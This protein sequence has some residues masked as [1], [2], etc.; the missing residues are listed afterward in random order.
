MKDIPEKTFPMAAEEGSESMASGED[1][2]G[3]AGGGEKLSIAKNED[4]VVWALRIFT[5][6]LLF[7]VAV[8][9]CVLA[10]KNA[11]GAQE[12]DFKQGFQEYSSKLMSGVEFYVKNRV[13]IVEGFAMDLSY[14]ANGS[15]PFY[16][17][18][19]Y[20]VRAGHVAKLANF[21]G[22]SLA[23][24][25]ETDQKTAWEAYVQEH[26]G[27]LAEELARQRGIP[28]EEVKGIFIPRVILA[29]KDGVPGPDMGEGPY[30]PAWMSYPP[31]AFPPLININSYGNP[32]IGR[33]MIDAA[34]NKTTMPFSFSEDFMDEP[35]TKHPVALL[36][37]EAL[38][39][40]AG[41]PFF[42]WSYP[43]YDSYTTSS[44]EE[45]NVVALVRGGST[46]DGYFAN[47][48]QSGTP[49]LF[50][51]LENKCNQ[52]YTFGIEGERAVVL[53]RG[54]LH[55]PKYDD[56]VLT[57]TLDSMWGEQ[58]EDDNEEEYGKAVPGVTVGD[59]HYRVRVYPTQEFEDSYYT[60]EPL[61]YTLTLAAVFLFTCMVFLAFDFFVERRQKA[62]LKS[63]L[64]SGKLVSTLFPE[65]VRNQLYKEEEAK[66][67]AKQKE[68]GWLAATTPDPGAVLGGASEG[69]TAKQAIANLYPETTIFF[70]DLAGFTKW[71]STRTPVE[72]FELL[73]ALYGQFDSIAARYNVFKV[74]TIGDCYVAVRNRSSRTSTRPCVDHDQ[75]LS[76][77]HGKTSWGA[78]I[79]G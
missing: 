60:N 51:V 9:V 36:A 61:L 30:F 56:V 72:V 47:I 79:F 32:E 31:M 15:W 2:P 63:A 23:I 11:Q 49:G 67:K 62:V 6:L 75:I 25:V 42:Q 58:N 57:M 24:K 53:G 4:K 13:G 5:T 50:L 40:Y 74:E 16:T 38:P 33:P 70:C 34:L 26:K 22:V 17:P 71:S 28:V 46:W 68:K 3:E 65:E 66:A 20:V 12:E 44:E 10:Y 1:S 69:I 14:A 21:V 41:E 19:G 43:V 64:Q 18:P 52:T 39:G 73:E 29:I 78:G 35:D 8:T 77:L 76:I 55:D 45:R 7:G 37:R 48:L 54:D 59:C 27:W